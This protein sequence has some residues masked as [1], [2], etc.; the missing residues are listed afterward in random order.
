MLFQRLTEE[1]N[2]VSKTSGYTYFNGSRTV[3]SFTEFFG[4]NPLDWPG[5]FCTRN[6]LVYC[7]KRFNDVMNY[8]DLSVHN[9]WTVLGI[10]HDIIK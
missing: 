6:R 3:E 10:G 7:T 2:V 5:L 9:N 1:Q 4:V 8:V